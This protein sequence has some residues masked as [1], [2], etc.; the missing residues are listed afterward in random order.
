MKNNEK[1]LLIELLQNQTTRTE[2]CVLLKTNDCSAR[3]RVREI[4]LEQPIIS[5]SKAK[6]YRICNVEKLKFKNN[7]DEIKNEILELEH[8]INEINSRIRELAKRRIPILKAL[9]ELKEQ[10]KND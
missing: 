8:T 1:E 4:S 10:L 7:H 3:D 2:L 6:G 9:K 5:H